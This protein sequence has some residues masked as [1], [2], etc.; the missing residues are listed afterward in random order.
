MG[1]NDALADIN[2]EDNQLGPGTFSVKIIDLERK[3]NVNVASEEVWLRALGQ[4]GADPNMVS[5]I[6]DAFADWVDPDDEKHLN[7]A[8]TRDYLQ[9]PNPGYPPYVAKNGPLDDLT[10]LLLIRGITPEMFWGPRWQERQFNIGPLNP[11]GPEGGGQPGGGSFSGGLVDMF[12]AISDGHVNINTAPAEVLQLIPGFDPALAQAIIMT[13]SGPDG[14]DGTDDDT[15]FRN[16]G[17][18]VNVPGMDRRG[19]NAFR[20]YFTTRSYTFEIQ[21]EARVGNYKRTYIAIVRRVSQLDARILFAYW[22]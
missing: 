16:P 12:T 3:F 4:I 10:E 9:S 19:V 18:V 20:A 7:G 2:L 11:P 6:F 22:R 1:T 21:V 15:P 14:I 8:E 13:R 17:E 5:P